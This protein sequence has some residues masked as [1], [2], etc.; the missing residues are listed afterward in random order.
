[1]I[2]KWVVIGKTSDSCIKE[3]TE[4]YL[5][6][7]KKYVKTEYVELS[8]IK[9]AKNLRVEQRKDK[10]AE[11]IMKQ[12]KTGDYLILLDEKGKSFTSVQWAKHLEKLLHYHKGNLI[13]VNGGAYGFSEALYKR[14]DE[15]LSLSK[16]TFSHQ[17][18][19]ILFA[20]QLYRA[21][22]IMHG[23]PYHNE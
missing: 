19:R 1:M 10:E 12:I 18:I 15:T 14:A 17:I 5:K 16:M 22:S 2:I 20:E 13:F 21:F 11:L 23:H 4:K 6:R 7:I 9:N 8:D 3:L